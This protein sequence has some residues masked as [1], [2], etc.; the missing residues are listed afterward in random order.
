MPL[1]GGMTVADHLLAG[2]LDGAPDAMLCLDGD[3]RI[4]LVNAQAEQLFGYQ[5]DVLE[6][7]PVETLVPDGAKA[8]HLAHRARYMAR[9]ALHPASARTEL[10]GRR[11]D[12]SVFP[13]EISLSGVGTGDGILVMAAVRDVTTRPERPLRQSQRLESLGQLTGGVA[14]SYHSLLAVISSY[15]A[16]ITEEVAQ[17]G[18]NIRWQSVRDDVAQIRQAAERATELT[19]QLLAFARR[20]VVPPRP[21]DLNEVIAGVEHLLVRTLGERVTLEMRL[22]AEPCVVLADPGQIEQVLVNLAVNARDAMPAGGRLVVETGTSYLDEVP[23]ASRGGLPHGQYACLTIS[24][25]GTGMTKGIL[26]RAFEPFFTTKPK[27]EG[28]GLGL[29][30]VYGIITQASGDV[31]IDSEPGQ[32]TTVTV[33]LPSIGPEAGARP[34]RA[35]AA[36]HG[37]GETVLVVEDEPAIREVTRRILA[38]SGYHV[39]TAASAR[40]AIEIATSAGGDIDVLLT[41]VV[42]PHMLGKEAADRIRAFRPDVKVLFMSGYTQGLLDTQGVAEAGVNLIEKPFTE[43]SLLAKLRQVI[44]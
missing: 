20:D 40:E 18:R 6:G 30:T 43:A 36:G 2:L 7:E 9:P 16:F 31:Q 33:L 26:E 5:R 14:H 23:A 1:E 21:L 42:M 15:A 4:V 29:A 38:R 11:R 24:D 3:G 44:G 37:A 13:A 39:L 25:T 8:A 27:G 19:L 22:A 12:G 34:D 10:S 35:Q 32:G 28:T 41:D 17:G